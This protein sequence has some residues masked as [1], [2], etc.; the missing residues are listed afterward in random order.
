MTEPDPSEKVRNVIDR[1]QLATLCAICSFIAVACDGSHPTSP[2]SSSS[3]S[4]TTTLHVEPDAAL[5]PD[6]PSG[7]VSLA[8]WPFEAGGA[9]SIDVCVDDAGQPIASTFDVNT[10]CASQGGIWTIARDQ[11][12]D[13][14]ISRIWSGRATVRFDRQAGQAPILFRS[15]YYAPDGGATR[16]ITDCRW[17]LAEH[18]DVGVACTSDGAVRQMPWTMTG[19]GSDAAR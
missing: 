5:S 16:D 4:G 17:L 15:A 18:S 13:P 7:M 2:D 9:V 10:G 8:V 3:L 14:W 12:G 6:D 19:T 1:Q 11:T